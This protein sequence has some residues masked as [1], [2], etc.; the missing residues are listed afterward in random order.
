MTNPFDEF[1]RADQQP[2]P[3]DEF[4][5]AD[6]Q[7]RAVLADAAKVNP[8]DATEA[9]RLA[10]RYPA[11]A[12]VLLR[13]LQDAKLQAAVDDADARLRTS[14]KLAEHM[15]NN[16]WLAKQAHDD[17]PVLTQVADVVGKLGRAGQAGVYGGARGAAG[18]FRAG[19]ELVAPLTDVL[20]PDEGV[21][22]WRRAIGGNP[23][24]RLAEGFGIQADANQRDAQAVR[25]TG[26]NWFDSGV[27]SGIESLTQNAITMPAA[28]ANPAAGL[29]A[30]GGF[31]GGNAYEDAR[32]KGLPM[33]QALPFA[34]SQTAIE[35]ATEKLPLAKLI[36]D[37]KAGTPFFQT[38]LK[39]VALEVP[40][41]QVATLLQDMNEWAVLNPDKPFSE[42]VA[43][44][45]SA[46]VQTLVATIVGTGGN[47]A[48]AKT[49]E[50]AVERATRQGAD[51]QR[52]GAYAQA[53]EQALK[54]AEASA[55][56]E[57]DPAAFRALMADLSDNGT[58]YVDAEVLN[59]M[60]TEVLQQM[61]GVADE[62][63]EA[64]ATGGTVGVKLADAMTLL[65]GTPQAELFMQ[66]AR[67][68]PDAPS[69]FEAEEA[70]KQAAEFL[71]QGAEE[72]I[73][74]AQD[75]AAAQASA[76]AVKAELQSQIAATGRYSPAVNE[77]MATWAAAFYTTMGARTGMT[78]QEFYQR[79]PLRVL[80][81]AQA[82]GQQV[83]DQGLSLA[84]GFQSLAIGDS[85]V[86]VTVKDGHAEVSMVKTPD[87]KRGQGSARRAME[88]VLRAADAQG[89]V[90]TLTPEPM[91]KRTS[92]AKLEKF[93]KSLG[94]TPNKG[95]A[96]DYRYSA[97]MIRQPKGP[98]VRLEQAGQ[99]D[100]TGEM[101]ELTGLPLN[102]DGTVT[103]YHH[104]SAE[105]AAEIRRTGVLRS[106]GEPDLYFTS[107]D[108]TDTG[109]GDTAIA[110]RVRPDRLQ[111]DDEFPDGRQDFRVETPGKSRRLKFL[112]DGSAAL[113][114]RTAS[115]GPRGTF[116]P[117]T[118]E[119]VL[120][121]NADLSTFFH[122]SGHF[123]LEV[124]ADLAS[125]PGAPAQIVDDMNKI[126]AWFGV[127]GVA[128]LEFA[129]DA[130]TAPVGAWVKLPYPDMRGTP[131]AQI[132]ELDVSEMYLPEL[133]E[134]GQLQPEKRGYL[135]GYAERA[136]A[137]EQ[138]PNIQVVEMEDGR[139][140]VVDGHR[141][142]MAARAAGKTTI[143]ATVS[144]LMDHAD[145]RV[146][147]VAPV[148]RT[149]LETWR[150]MTLDQKR[151]YHERWAE[152]IE[153]Y[154][155]EGKAPST[156]LQGPMRRFAAWLKSVYGSI[157]AFLA[158]RGVA[159][160]G[161]DTLG[162]G[163]A[164]DPDTVY[165]EIASDEEVVAALEAWMV[166]GALPSK[167][168]NDKLLAYM[169]RLPPVPADS[170]LTFYRGQPKGAKPHARGW[171]SWSTSKDATRF[172]T[173]GGGE[174]L[175][176]KGARGINLEEVA[177]WR[178]RATGQRHDY[179]SQGE[180]L[181]LNESVFNQGT[182]PAAG[183][184]IQLNDDIR[185]VMDR[186]LATDEQIQQANDAAGLT[187]DKDA[188]AEAAERLRKRSIADLKWAV[189]ARDKVIAKLRKQAASIEKGIRE[190]VTVEVDATPEMRAKRAL[191]ALRKG[192]NLN[193]ATQATTAD[194]FGYAS[195]EQMLQAIDAYGSRKDAIDAITQRR[196]L[197]E[198][199]DLVDEDAIRL[200]ANEAVHNE[201][202]ARS[203]AT[204]LRTQREMLNPR[205]DTGEV[206]A[207]GSRITVNTLLVASRQ[208][209]AGV[210][211]RTT[212]A[213]LKARIW[214]HTGAERRAAKRWAEATAAGKTEEAVKAKQ[215]QMLHHAAATAAMQART[216][217]QKALDFFKRVTKGNSETVVE[218]GRDADVV[219]AARAVL[220]AYGVNTPT[221]RTALE[222]LEAVKRNDPETYNVLA[223]IVDGATRNAM[224]LDALTF[225]QLQA[226]RDDIDAMWHLA[227]RMR[228]MEVAGNLI[229]IEDAADEMHARMVE[230]GIP[231]TVPGEAG[232]VTKVEERKRWVQF[233]RALLS[234]VEQWTERMDGKWGGPFTRYVFQ[235]VKQAADAYRADRLV[236][237]RKYQALVDSVAPSLTHGLIEA[238]E[239]GY[240]FGR[241]HNGI[242]GAELLH[243]IL[244]TGN[245]SNKRK[246]LL[247]RQW[248]EQ[249]ADGTLDTR[250]WDAFITRMVNEGKLTKAHYDFA[251]GV[252]D[253]LEETKPLA[254]KAHRDVFGRYFAE[255]T[256]DEFVTPFG[257]YRG[258]YVPAQAD[259]AIV[260][261]AD[262][263]ALAE[264]ENE[265]MAYSFPA[266]NKGF[267]KS[268]VEYNRPLKL[269]LRTIPQHLD[270]VLLFSHMEP[271]VRGVTKLLR[272]KGVSQ[273]LG[274][275]D[276]AAYSGMLLPWLNR[277]AR[278]QVETPVMGDGRVSRVLSALRS[279]AGAAVMFANLSN[280]LQQVT[281]FSNALVLVKGS[282]IRRGVAQMIA[283]P[284]QTRAAVAALSPYMANRMSDEVAAMNDEMQA[285]LL[286]P[287]LYERAQAWAQR[288]SYFLQSA[289]DNAMSP[290]IWLGAYNQALA[291]GQSEA[292]AVAFADGVIRK[293]QG[294]TLP[295]DVSRMET[296][297]AYARM[298]TQ[299]VGYFNM[300][301]NTNGTALAQIAGEM[302][303]R[304]G[305]GKALG[306]LFYGMLAPIW[307]AEAIALAFKG[308][309]DD[310]DDDGYL[311]DWLAAV[312]GMGTIKGTLA[313][314]PFVAQLGQVVV[315]RFNPNP[316]DDRFSLSP[317]VS[318]LES[319]AS[320]P[321]DVYK[322]ITDGELN[323]K[324]I[325]DSAALASLVTGMPVTAFAKPAG[326]AADV[327]AGKVDPTGP[328][329]TAR[330]LVTG[331]A[332]PDSKQ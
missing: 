23:L 150:S 33:S 132:R 298:F 89:L 184:Q 300:M 31:T 313:Q 217:A 61:Q 179:G 84:D 267:T 159:P 165:R 104:T 242:G 237:R 120:S 270:K 272:N 241:G 331:I 83:M 192:K 113:Y 187:P 124:M 287:S 73:A 48:V 176:R 289:V 317:A 303:L 92:K 5:R 295:E 98:A 216:E 103:V 319:A 285:I 251:Q 327:A 18:L 218:K 138:P 71:R 166:D 140:R 2:S 288:H 203:L 46:A 265:S 201:A 261:D 244:H 93:Y 17:V 277:S 169:R 137:G 175:T 236:Y 332:S 194:A 306:V 164:E 79:F 105:R 224:P 282:H 154:V 315:N 38:L 156:E 188:D 199:G 276:P 220:A 9:L 196:M 190:Q 47:V 173:E 74:Q 141:R 45:P 54:T 246:L 86:S 195:V 64:L 142:V 122:E 284:K 309:P 91:D 119:L 59:Q 133:D 28:L 326:Y 72:A 209:A 279:R 223:P 222:Y 232:A 185:R 210:V 11:P 268:R 240:T 215:D 67:V 76:D 308:G 155:M 260:N 68:R 181:V 110:V 205:A 43:E 42:Y 53:L 256:A 250:R 310:E 286:D 1:P 123:F 294:S 143:R 77:G 329:D 75:Q 158:S 208:F 233:A 162:Q 78:A 197:E 4:P 213:D 114:Q 290:M 170:Y 129:D 13:N 318:L 248:A 234:R 95:R 97:A 39:Q 163:T 145:G 296:G 297:P 226:L 82:G 235:P 305:A 112:P 214:Q 245:E 8:E 102:S 225:E 311:D 314:V 20:E 172:F 182:E 128:P 301:A 174:V 60:P 35:V 88:Q 40:G 324:L 80:G 147:M 330:G 191:D 257:T 121:P 269:D 85:E 107:T 275:I 148:A 243:A 219:N 152:S 131:V 227:K 189:A 111:I 87:D 16:P 280:T 26:T 29:A 65:A 115:V 153:Q 254:Q 302:G 146:P 63:P 125:Q 202:R 161:G 22:D 312:F 55:L 271:A 49:I 25:P 37:V 3:F 229:D 109:Y 117:R 238:P 21:N 211:A 255:V 157:K 212:L 56:R 262:M 118:L 106:A 259:P 323:K 206:N 108:T 291:E 228:Q 204:E 96:K 41:E 328:V 160:A 10:K 149:P 322:A 283:H 57:R 15:R 258:G 14:P 177:L 100:R 292:D 207:A 36:G 126:L 151:P 230:V 69:A 24:R 136:R 186:M 264:M 307:V 239:L 168:V 6:G 221:T 320:V 325:R 34:A 116:N 130:E 263:R 278:Q 90:V 321:F 32:A 135:E 94:F 19:F 62:L 200:A 66:H 139:L 180:W 266:T 51:M 44:R 273:A 52:S 252:W 253:L 293:T 101:D 99:N 183:P 274:R 30:M 81:E 247:G 167:Q 144:P 134:N 281:G 127:K 299:F 7:T 193:D 27:F 198:H 249:N 171:A 178:T 50:T 231:D 316:A 304:K 58:V 12:D 70:G